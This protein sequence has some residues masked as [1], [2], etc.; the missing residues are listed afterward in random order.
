MNVIVTGAA[1]FVGSNLTGALLKEGH[2]VTGIDNFSYGFKRNIEPF[3]EHASFRFIEGDVKD[4]ALLDQA[5]GDVLVHLASQKIPRYTNAFKTLEDNNVMLK[6]VVNKCIADKIKVV[7]ASTSDVYGKNT[8]LPFAETSN[9]VMGPPTVKRWAYAISKLYSEQYL[10][11]CSEESGLEFC[12]MRFF[13]A[14][15]PNQ[16]MTWWGGP[17]SVFI[18][19]IIEGKPIEL[20]GDGMQTRTFTFV[21]DTV[22]G[23]M[24]CIF[25][26][27]SKN[28]VFNIAN[29]PTEETTIKDLAYLICDLMREKYTIPEI[30]LI[31]YASFGNYEDV[32]RRIPTI[33]KIKTMLGYEPK[34]MMR[35]GLKRAIEWQINN[36]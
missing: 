36:Q 24:K 25:H 16:N 18:Q 8:E 22:Q 33:E 31:P 10:F 3:L 17:Q 27:D 15:G 2:H 7:F 14:Y 19:N 13:G 1:G 26:P 35:E 28:Q 5:K 32:M 29:N 11:A 23:I 34:Y 9:L 21:D 12:I 4:K 20:H 6:N 30:K